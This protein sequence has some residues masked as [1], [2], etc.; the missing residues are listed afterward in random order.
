MKTH[1]YDGKTRGKLAIL[2]MRQL[3]RGSFL[4]MRG[5]FLRILILF[6]DSFKEIEN[7]L[8]YCEGFYRFGGFLYTFLVK[9]EAFLKAFEKIRE[10]EVFFSNSRH[11]EQF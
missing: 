7:F 3:P 8:N 11:F 5:F 1:K 9:I 2:A 10:M 4:R 6:E